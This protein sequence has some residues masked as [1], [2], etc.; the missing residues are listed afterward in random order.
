MNEKSKWEFYIAGVKHHQL[1]TVI[2]EIEEGDILQL[3]PEP[4]N[5]Y[6]KHAVKVLFEE[7]MLGYV[8][9]KISQAVSTVLKTEGIKC[10]VIRI[11]PDNMPWNQ[12]MVRVSP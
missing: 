6:D 10:E 4:T 12:L 9:G 5:K 3:E 7:V 11:S 8:P 1:H 2:D